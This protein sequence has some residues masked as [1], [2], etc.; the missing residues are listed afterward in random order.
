MSA[1]LKCY[2]QARSRN[3]WEWPARVWR[4]AIPP[5]RIGR[6]VRGLKIYMCLRDNARQLLSVERTCREIDSVLRED[7]ASMWD[8]G[9]NIGLYSIV[10]AADGK[11]VRAFDISHKAIGLLNASAE[12]NGLELLA[13]PRA[14]TVESLRYVPATDA[15]TENRLTHA[16][17]GVGAQ[18]S[19]DFERAAKDYGVPDLIK[20]DIEGGELEFLN[21]PEFKRW[22]VE[23][24]I[25]LMIELHSHTAEQ[26]VWKDL[27]LRWIDAK[28]V[29]INTTLG[30]ARG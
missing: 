11:R 20:M 5:L 25:I 4:R 21:A 3:W 1:K 17:A 16:V 9:C 15:H 23:N 2:R 18:I 26:A 14:L 7:F 24:K 6:R 28:H 8:L 27:P 10:A 29:V 22:V 13:V 30:G 19:I 12:A